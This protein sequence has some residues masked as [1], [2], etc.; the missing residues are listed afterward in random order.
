MSEEWCSNEA[1][2]RLERYSGI[3]PAP[4]CWLGGDEVDQGPSYCPDCADKH[5]QAGRASFVDG[6]WPSSG[7]DGCIHCYDCGCILD[8]SLTPSGV[9]EELFHFAS[10]R[11]RGRLSKERAFHIARLLDAAPSDG[12]VIRLGQ[13][14]LRRI[15]TPGSGE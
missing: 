14:A 7:E 2:R 5:V 4:L 13:R 9:S 1:A 15:A 11:F 10:V 12:D 8:Y 3:E 6:G